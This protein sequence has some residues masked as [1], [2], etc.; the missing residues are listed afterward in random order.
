MARKGQENLIPQNKRTKDEQRKIARQGG[1]ASGKA[2]RKIKDVKEAFRIALGMDGAKK[3]DVH[4]TNAE[5]IAAVTMEEILK[6]RNVKWL[7]V[8]MDALYGKEQKID[9]VSSDGSMSPKSATFD[10]SGFTPEQIADLSQA[11]FRGE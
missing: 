10:L 8:L 6:N 1:I 9:H 2:R 3:G 11:A 7:S 5:S 4:L